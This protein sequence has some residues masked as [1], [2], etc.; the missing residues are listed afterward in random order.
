[1]TMLQKIKPEVKPPEKK[2]PEKQRG[3]SLL[4]LLIYIGILSLMSV[5]L[6]GAFV[7]LTRGRAQSTARSEV[8]SNAR[9]VLERITQD[10]SAASSVT[11][12]VLGTA[13]SALLLTGS[14]STISYDVVA[15]VLRRIV[16][17]GS[18]ERLTGTSV[19]VDSSLF[20]RI[21]NYNTTLAATT[22]S[23]QVLMTIRSTNAAGES[24]YSNVIRTTV[25]VR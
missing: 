2:P 1:M 9:F 14:G 23:I 11:T 6:A 10:V 12:P 5:I 19:V 22:T 4:E 15:G 13:S 21:E 3:F 20:T 18:A 25:D 24:A 8:E 7:S 17:G 16:N